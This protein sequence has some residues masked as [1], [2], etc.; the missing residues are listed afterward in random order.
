MESN[1]INED[2][3]NVTDDH[4]DNCNSNCHRLSKHVTTGHIG[5]VLFANITASEDSA[6]KEKFAI[7]LIDTDTLLFKCVSF[8]YFSPFFENRVI[9]LQIPIE[10]A[11]DIVTDSVWRIS[12]LVDCGGGHQENKKGKTEKQDDDGT[13]SDCKTANKNFF[14]RS[15][16]VLPKNILGLSCAQQNQFVSK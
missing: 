15:V 5:I 12:F 7:A 16:A 9:R 13:N 1:E 10:N 3:G 8:V 4:V 11:I 6:I 14:I 2:N